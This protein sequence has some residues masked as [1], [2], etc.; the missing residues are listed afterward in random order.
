[1]NRWGMGFLVL[2][3]VSQLLHAPCWP[4]WD[5]YRPFGHAVQWSCLRG[6]Q[7]G[8]EREEVGRRRRRKKEGGEGKGEV[9]VQVEQEVEEDTEGQETREKLSATATTQR[10]RTRTT[11]TTRM[12]QKD[13]THIVSVHEAPET[14]K[15]V[16]RFAPLQLFL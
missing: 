5:W 1:M 16:H 15:F 14:R 11:R 9:Q 3:H 12:K 8:K 7:K 4:V 2:P 10:Y 6:G 13:I